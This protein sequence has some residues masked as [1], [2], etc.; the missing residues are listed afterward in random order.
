MQE[1]HLEMEGLSAPA[2]LPGSRGV[3]AGRKQYPL[4]YPIITTK[5]QSRPA[6]QRIY[7]PSETGGKIEKHNLFPGTQSSGATS[8]GDTR[9]NLVKLGTNQQK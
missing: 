5:E 9:A 4:S 1:A 6:S 3:T 8:G 2:Q 7:V